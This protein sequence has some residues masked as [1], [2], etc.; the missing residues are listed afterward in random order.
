MAQLK[1]TVVSGSLRATDTLY[2]TTAQFQILN[3]MGGN[4]TVSRVS[5]NSGVNVTQT[6]VPN[7]TITLAF[8]TSG[9]QGIWST[10]YGASGTSTTDGKWLVYRNSSG[11][12]IFNG[13]SQYTY[14]ST[15]DFT[16]ATNNIS[17][18]I[19]S[20][21]YFVG[22]SSSNGIARLRQN[23]YTNGNTSLALQS[24]NYN[25]STSSWGDYKGII[26]QT[27]KDN[28]VNYVIDSPQNFLSAL[29]VVYSDTTPSSPTEGM[30]WLKPI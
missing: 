29:G 14:P 13:L 26:I 20:N 28:T 27:P 21:L 11:N 24:R 3:V 25:S 10:G 1:D 9:S 22:D 12:I 5:G 2:S 4:L 15:V 18:A 19:N 17:T 7:Q 16:S 23:V 8:N 6:T 30:I